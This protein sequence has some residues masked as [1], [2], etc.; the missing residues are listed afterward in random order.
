[1]FLSK[2]SHCYPLNA[3]TG[4][5]KH[6]NTVRSP[7]ELLPMLTTNLPGQSGNESLCL[8]GHVSP[9]LCKAKIHC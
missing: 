4:A 7:H 6:A 1:M 3:N 2:I 9:F 5:A 8:S